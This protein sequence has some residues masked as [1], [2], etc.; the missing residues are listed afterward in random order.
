MK[1][2]KKD[3]FWPSY[4]D[5]LT[6]LFIVM[7]VLFVLS[8]K[9]LSD[10]KEATEEE[11]NKIKEIQKISENLPRKFFEYQKE[12][13]RWTL[14]QPTQFARG[15][16]IIPQADYRYLKEVGDSLVAMLDTLQRRYGSDSLKYL[17]IIE[18]MSSKIGIDPDPQN[19]SYR[20]ARSLYEFWK[21]KNIIFDP[22]VCEV[23]ISGSG[24]GG[25]GRFPPKLES[26][27]QRILI[28]VV[29]KLSK[30]INKNGSP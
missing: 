29:P 11:L 22:E 9:L 23:M 30:F 17:M 24:V 16:D 25:I 18:G 14:I 15:S 8:Y 20:R 2:S 4:V 13:K 7:L 6:G 28:Q 1:N 26:N 21:S 27:N 10:S 5:L 12:F 3:F 19:L